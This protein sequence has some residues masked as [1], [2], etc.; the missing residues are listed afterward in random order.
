MQASLF[1]SSSLVSLDERS[2]CEINS[3]CRGVLSRGVSY[4]SLFSSDGILRRRA[5]VEERRC[6]SSDSGSGGGPGEFAGQLLLVDA[7]C[8]KLSQSR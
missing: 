3:A 5:L 6:V 2:L 4:M 7:G 8:D 1:F